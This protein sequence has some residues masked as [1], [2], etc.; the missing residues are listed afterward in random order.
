MSPNSQ[1]ATEIDLPVDPVERAG[2]RLGLAPAELTPSVRAA[3]AHLQSEVE[4]LEG[5]LADAELLADLDPLTP[6]LNRRAFERELGRAMASARRYG[7]NLSLVYFDLNGF[8]QVN[9]TYGHAAGDA[10][11]KEVA[12]RLTAHFR[13]EDTVG[14]LG[15]DEFAIICENGPA[16]NEVLVNRVRNTLATPYSVRGDLI[17]ATVSIGIA[18]PQ[19]GESSTQMLERA[20]TEMYQAKAAQHI[21]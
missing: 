6:I 2:E 3:L 9:D 11:L 12:N 1:A 15:G 17:A 4:R 19:P 21:L 8:K 13:T 16:S 20:D 7:E 5:K 10:V 14:R 18:S